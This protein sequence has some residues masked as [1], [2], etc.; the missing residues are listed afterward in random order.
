MISSKLSEPIEAPIEMVTVQAKPGLVANYQK[1]L[2]SDWSDSFPQKTLAL[3]WG[4]IDGRKL[5]GEKRDLWLVLKPTGSETFPLEF[6]R[7]IAARIA[8]GT[9][10]VHGISLPKLSADSFPPKKPSVLFRQAYALATYLT[11]EAH[12][13]VV[14]ETAFFADLQSLAFQSVMHFMLPE[15][16]GR[17]DAEHALLLHTAA[18][19]AV[20][21]AAHDPAHYSYMMSMIHDYLGDQEQKLKTLFASFRFTSPEDHSYLTKAQEYWM[22]LLDQAKPEQAEQFLLSL[23]WWSLPN[24]QSEVRE[25][26][27]DAFKYISR[28]QDLPR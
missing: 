20:G 18:L 28:H 3:L 17:H 1:A 6:F 10:F 25:M 12:D 11:L 26:V 27:A 19:F 2:L 24:Q 16:Q 9:R 14:G 5:A 13:R 7:S 4:T 8:E 23:H 15:L 22:E 21:Y